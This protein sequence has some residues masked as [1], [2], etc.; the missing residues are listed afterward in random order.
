MLGDFQIRV[1]SVSSPSKRPEGH[2]VNYFVFQILFSFQKKV[3]FSLHTSYPSLSPLTCVIDSGR[4]PTM[5]EESLFWNRPRVLR[6][7]P[8]TKPHTPGT[9]QSD[10][11]VDYSKERQTDRGCERERVGGRERGRGR[12]GRISIYLSFSLSLSLSLS[13]SIYLSIYQYM[14]I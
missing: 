1:L 13:L 10:V 5:S 4:G 9:R 12:E 8:L 3:E 11:K 6:A 14:Y 2:R 7:L